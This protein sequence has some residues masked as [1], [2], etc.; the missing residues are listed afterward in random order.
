MFKGFLEH[1]SLEI[2]V[3]PGP[4]LVPGRGSL[5]FRFILLSHL[6]LIIHLG[7]LIVLIE[8]ILSLHHPVPVAAGIL[9]FFT[10]CVRLA[11]T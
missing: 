9:V 8:V 11:L 6:D 5:R 2:S 1:V 10:A 3:L 7:W 4:C